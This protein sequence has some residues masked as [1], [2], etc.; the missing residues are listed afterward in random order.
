MTEDKEA[1]EAIA[2]EIYGVSLMADWDGVDEDDKPDIDKDWYE[3]VIHHGDV[4]FWLNSAKSLIQTLA[5]LGYVRMVE[6]KLP[7]KLPVH[8]TFYGD[9]YQDAQQAMLSIDS[10]GCKWV[11]VF[12]GKK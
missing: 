5:S 7:Q 4:D 8:S 11:R 3:F 12:V 2:K 6:Q 1:I 10:E 9:G